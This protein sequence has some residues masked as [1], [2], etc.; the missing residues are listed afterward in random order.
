M[1]ALA[2]ASHSEPT[3]FQQSFLPATH[4]HLYPLCAPAVR[5]HHARSPPPALPRLPP[6][7]RCTQQAPGPSP[8]RPAPPAC[9]SP[10][11]Q[12]G[13][14][15]LSTDGCPPQGPPAAFPCGKAA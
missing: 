1:P 14:L 6:P 10:L 3:G 13:G 11:G 4:R 8:P 15:L 2:F 5:P 9:P 12:R 7:S